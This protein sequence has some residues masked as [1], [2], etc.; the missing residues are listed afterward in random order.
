MYKRLTIAYKLLSAKGLIWI[1]ID[2]N[3][4]FNLKLLCDQIFNSDNFRSLI[5]VIA[6][7]G[8]R[9]YGGIAKKRSIS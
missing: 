4:L 3:E 5:T 2:E 8:G 6:N 7:P 1:S 9:D